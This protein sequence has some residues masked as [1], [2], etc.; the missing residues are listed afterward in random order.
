[1]P[2]LILYHEGPDIPPLGADFGQGTYD[3]LVAQ[4]EMMSQETGEPIDAASFATLILDSAFEEATQ[5][6][7]DVWTDIPA[8]EVEGDFPTR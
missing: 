5:P 6:I 8:L 3:W 2:R 7:G 4:A 1:M